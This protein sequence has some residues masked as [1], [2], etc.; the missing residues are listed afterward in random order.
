MNCSSLENIKSFHKYVSILYP[1]SDLFSFSSNSLEISF[2]NDIDES[3]S[4][5]SLKDQLKKKSESSYD[6]Q[7][8]LSF[9]FDIERN[10]CFDECKKNNKCNCV[11]R[12]NNEE[13]VEISIIFYI[14]RKLKKICIINFRN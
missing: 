6:K 12:S 1:P 5:T 14:I 8:S 3:L 7:D 9:L 11:K 4:K 10:I 2:S 13:T